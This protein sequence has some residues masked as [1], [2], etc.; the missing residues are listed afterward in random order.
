MSLSDP[1]YFLFL[2]V[3]FLL[4]HLL[5]TGEPR[6]LL[7]LAS[8][9]FF[10]YELSRFYILVLFFVTLICYFGAQ[11]LRSPRVR[12]RSYLFFWLIIALTLMPLLV[13]RYLG[14]FISLSLRENFLLLAFPVGISFFTFAALGY[15]I[16]VY[17]EVVEPETSP[18]RFALFL[19]F[20]PLI[21]AGPIE[22][23]GRFMSQFDFDL[24][25]TSQRALMALRLVFI[26]LLMKLVFADRLVIPVDTV[27]DNLDASSA[28]ETMC[29]VFYYPFYLYAD[30]AGYSLIAI[31]SAK[32][33][34]LE[35]RP[36]FQ[37]PFLSTTIPEFWRCWH[38]SLSSWVRDYLFTP[39]RAELRYLGNWGMATAL[40]LSFVILGVW[41]GAKLGYFFFGLIHGCYAVASLFTLP[42]R[43]Q[44]VARLRIPASV[45]YGFRLI[46]TFLLVSIAFVPFRADT[47][48]Q[49]VAIY[50]NLFSPAPFHE[51]LWMFAALA[52][53]ANLDSF[54][55]LKQFLFVFWVIPFLLVGD[56]LAR[57]N[58]AFERL[59]L[60]PQIIGYNWGLLLIISYWLTHYGS[61]PFVYYK[62]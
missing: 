33:F 36:N 43:N 25:F 29:A 1:L 3:V 7:L 21:S 45:V 9:Y 60:L 47:M 52:H 54:A 19:A 17:L 12:N 40:L 51:L 42:W 15:I 27:Y 32:L 24:P 48:Q 41:H 22:R 35:V 20:F 55:L 58:L 16:D 10:Y 61:Q 31:G 23:A 6:R 44:M 62:F 13:F 28:L 59:P 8:S 57:K 18:S 39:L 37:Q 14:V 38:I 2:T 34:G 53:H 50:R 4:F 49:T 5:R 11:G 46:V 26:G 56:L 30:F